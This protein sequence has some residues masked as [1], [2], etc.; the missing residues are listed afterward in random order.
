MAR[1]FSSAFSTESFVVSAMVNSQCPGWADGRVTC[2][3][4]CDV[5]QSPLIWVNIPESTMP[6]LPRGWR[7]RRSPPEPCHQF[8]VRRVAELVDRGDALDPVAALDQDF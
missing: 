8:H 3:R 5:G 7:E 4:K 6:N 2:P 1:S